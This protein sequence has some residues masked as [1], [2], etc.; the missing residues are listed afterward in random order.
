MKVDVRTRLLIAT[1]FTI[2]ALI[3]QDILALFLILT[4]NIT[5][6]TVFK[7]PLNIY[8]SMKPLLF[9]YVILIFIQS[10]FIEGGTPLFQVGGISFLTV[11]Y[12]GFLSLLPLG[13]FLSVEILRNC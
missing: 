6:L 13:C 12:C 9:L 7:V 1:I 2:M 10:I 8:R 11:S 4:V 5:V 3:Y